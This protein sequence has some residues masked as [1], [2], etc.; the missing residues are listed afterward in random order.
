MPMNNLS[1]KVCIIVGSTGG[2][3]KAIAHQLAAENAKIYLPGRNQS[4]LKS[5]AKELQKA[6]SFVQPFSMD[7]Q[8]EAE[9]DQFVKHIKEKEGLVDILIHTGGLYFSGKWEETEMETFDN[10]FE[11]NVRGPFKLT[12]EL[13]PLFNRHPGQIVVINSSVGLHAKAGVGLFSATQHALKALTDS[14]R[15]EIN[16]SGIRV[17]SVYPGRT[18]TGRVKTIFNKENRSYQPE[19]LLQPEDIAEIVL[20][21]LQLPDTA[22]ITDL[23]IRPFK[24]SY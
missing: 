14:L 19:L 24:K 5:L 21:T 12:R 6:S 4:S 10:L 15:A 3:G 2:I 20:K 7:L 13:I 18:N 11:A 22:E 9:I 17:M 1:G 23:H 16:E 8:N